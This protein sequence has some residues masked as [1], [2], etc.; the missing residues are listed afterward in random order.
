MATT[1][2]PVP[3]NLTRGPQTFQVRRVRSAIMIGLI[4]LAALVSVI[5]L[6]A[7]LGWVF[8]QGLPALNV[9][10]FTQLPGPPDDP[11]QGVANGIVGTVEL[12]ALASLISVPIGVGAGIYIAEFGG[13]RY[14]TLLR[15]ATDVLSGVPSITIGIFVYAVVVLPTSRFSLLAGG[16]ALALVMLPILI[17]TTE[18]MLRLVPSAIREA[19][20]ALGAPTWKTILRYALPAALPGIVT[21][22]LLAMARAAGET[23]PLLFTALGNNQWNTGLDQPVDALTLKVY[24]YAGQAY[25]VW[26]REAWAGAVVLTLMILITS[27]LARVATRRRHGR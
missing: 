11:H 8:F 14:N 7:V 16:I 21:G 4:W 24:F 22:A 13:S 2:V 5:P 18:E 26:R 1:T 17:R 3:R 15:F 9:D 12:L 23:A 20:L 25:D 6:L 19:A 27:I 10:F